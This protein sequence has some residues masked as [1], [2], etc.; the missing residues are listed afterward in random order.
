MPCRERMTYNDE[1]RLLDLSCISLVLLCYSSSSPCSVAFRFVKY[2]RCHSSNMCQSIRTPV[3]ATL[4][5]V[6]EEEE[7]ENASTSAEGDAEKAIFAVTRRVEKRVRTR[8]GT[9]RKR[10]AVEEGITFAGVL[11]R[12]E[13]LVRVKLENGGLDQFIIDLDTEVVFI[14]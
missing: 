5:P 14:A 11:Q 3:D 6:P 8:L 10:R 9:A 2:S 12:L 13:A 7:P 4:L 1:E